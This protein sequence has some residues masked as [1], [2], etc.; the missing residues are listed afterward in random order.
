[1]RASP[2]PPREESNQGGETLE[3]PAQARGKP[4]PEEFPPGWEAKD[5]KGQ[6]REVFTA[7]HDICVPEGLPLAALTP[8][9]EKAIIRCLRKYPDCEDYERALNRMA[10]H[11]YYKSPKAKGWNDSLHWLVQSDHL[12]RV[13][14]GEYERRQAS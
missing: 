1:M 6:A 5:L 3:S 7:W 4:V 11:P 2:S 10:T 13:I 14:T 12:K 8:D 9:L